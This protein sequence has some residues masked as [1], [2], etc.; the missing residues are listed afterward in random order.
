MGIA[1][2]RIQAASMLMI[3][4]TINLAFLYGVVA[5]PTISYHLST[6]LDYNGTI[7][8]DGEDLR[9]ELR[10]R[11]RGLSSA[12]VWLVVRYYN[13]TPT[14]TGGL[15]GGEDDGP[16][17]VRIPWRAPARQTD[18]AT[19]EVTFDSARNATYLVLIFY[20]E[21]DNRGDPATRFH[22]SFAVYRPERPTALLLKHT[23]N[24]KFTRVRR[25]E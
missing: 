20:V 13:M 4:V 3:A 14:S 23:G 17:E 10:A 11:N 5:R 1:S 22:N 24:M 18:Y 2:S 8:F 9:V 12:Q 21:T 15:R 25:R 19:F 6:P 7:D 16:P